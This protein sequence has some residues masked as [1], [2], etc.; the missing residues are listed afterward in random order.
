MKTTSL[1]LLLLSNLLATTSAYALPG[2]KDQPVEIE[3]DQVKFDE[4]SGISTYTGSVVVV[5]GSLHAT[6]DKVTVY[7]VNDE[8]TKVVATGK[9]AT[10]RQRPRL[11]KEE[12]HG[13]GARIEY[14]ADSEKVILTVNAELEQE[15]NLLRGQR[16]V[17][18]GTNDVATAG[19]GATTAEGT[20]TPSTNERVRITI[21]PKKDH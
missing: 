17:Y 13:K 1:T 10:F 5:Q 16:I 7:T 3:A 6:A 15:G 14:Y 21:Q 20:A 11:D 18:D 2:D 12:V 19:G 8:L 9:P 4:R